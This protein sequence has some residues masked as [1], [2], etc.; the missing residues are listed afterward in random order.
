MASP[1]SHSWSEDQQ[2]EPK[3]ATPPALHPALSIVPFLL[4]N[5]RMILCRCLPCPHG[6]YAPKGADLAMSLCP[7]PR[8]ALQDEATVPQQAE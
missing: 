5:R 3:S 2:E 6:S 1:S 4:P 7:H 8:P